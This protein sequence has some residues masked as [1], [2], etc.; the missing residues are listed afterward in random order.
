M[1]SWDGLLF[2]LELALSYQ[3]V[4]AALAGALAGTALGVLPGLGPTAGIALI[5]PLTYAFAPVTGLIMMA[6]M[7]Y[8]AMYGGSITAILMNIPGESS[9]IVTCIDGNKLTRKGRAGAALFIVALGSFIGGTISVFGVLLFAP[10]LAQFGIMFGPAE[11]FAITAGGLLMLSR[12]SGGTLAAGLFPMA[13]GLLIST[14]GQEAVTG[15]NRFTFGV[16]YLSQGV[17]LITLVIGVYAV[18]EMINMVEARVKQGNPP[19]VRVREMLPTRTEW[20]R[21]LPSY[22]RG[23][24]LGFA[25]GLLPGPSSTLASFA[26]YRLEKSVSKHR[27][28]IGEGAVEGIAGPDAATNAAATSLMVPLL[29]LGIPFNGAM[30]LMLA[31]LMVHGVQPGPLLA[32]VNPDIFWTII[33]SMFIG[34][35]ILLVLNIPMIGMWV[36][37]LRV[38]NFIFLPLILLLAIAGCYSMRNSM[39]DVYMLLPFGILGYVLR[40]FNFELAPLV[41]GAVLGPMIEKHL[42]EGL[43]MS[44]GDVAV[45]YSS[46]IAV[47]VWVFVIFVMT[48]GVQK[49]VF[50]RLSS[51]VRSART[52]R[53]SQ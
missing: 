5:L 46:P 25:F 43:F 27:R 23:T 39:L 16:N 41:V 31:A 50:R 19:A 51:L 22:A 34:N 8:G 7:L 38:P 13:I 11:L 33:A 28:E 35:A 6:G 29:G 44:Q 49:I 26:S 37:L 32:I 20:R 17:G 9:S 1:N 21:S 24:V 42:R 10:S 48:L 30:A 12:I 45:F 47:A 4:L 52:E 3:N 2:G 36:R 15:V 53:T 18:S 40:K 14:V